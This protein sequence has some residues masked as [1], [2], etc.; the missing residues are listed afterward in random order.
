MTTDISV[1]VRWDPIN[2]Q[3][4]V[5]EDYEFDYDGGNSSSRLFERSRIKALAVEREHVQKK[6]F[7]KWVNSHLCRINCRVVDLYTDLRDGKLLIKLLEILSGERLPRPTRGKMRI[8]CLENVDKA[9]SFLYEQR[10]HLENMGAHDI[11]DGSPR[12][13][14]GLIWTIILRFQIQ[15]ITVEEPG[16]GAATRSAKDALLLWCQMK[17]AGYHNVN[18]R[19]FTTSWR[20]G[21]A[22]NAIIHKHRSD[23][24]QYERL[25]KSNAMYNLNNA[26][27]VADREFNLV[28]LLDA[29]DVNVE[30]PDEKSI[31]T[32]VVTYYHYFSKL[33]QETVQG[34]RIAKVVGIDMECD[35]MIEQYEGFT[36][37]LLKW[38]EN[39]IEAL[40]DRQFANSL[41]GVQEQ[42][43]QFN[44]YRNVEKPPKFMEKGN[45]EVLLFTLQSKMRANN[46]VPYFPKEGKTIS[47]INKAWER[48]EKA[49]HERELALREELIRQEKLEQL[50]ARFNR[51]AGMR[52]T[53][54]SENQRLVSQD[55]FGF[56]LAAVEAAAKKHEAIET[57]IFAYE[58]R[59]QA[60]IA[61]AHELETENYHDIECINARKDNVLRLWNYLLE[62]LKARRTR[63]EMSL[64]LQHNFQEMVYIL[65]SMEELK[66]RLLS[67]D[68]GKH[69]L[70]VEDLLQKHSLV[71]A[72]INVLGERVKQVVQHSQKFLADE[73]G[74]DD[75]KPCDPSII[76]ER[77]QT[78][79][80]AYAELVRLAVERRSRLEESRQMWQFYWDMAEE[81]NW[82]KEMEQI[83][84]QGDIGHDLT[85]IHLLLSKHKSL[86]TEIR[87]HEN[88]LQMSIKQGQDLIDQ[89]HFGADKVQTRIDDVMS[90]WSQ[91]VDLMDTRKRR[92]TEAVDFH[93]FL[94]DADD[95]DTYMLDVLRL[96]S[97]D[98][99]GKDE[100]NV[101]TLLKK[102]K[103]IHDD[104]MNFQSNVDAL[105]EQATTLGEN[106]K[107]AVEKRLASIDKRY[108]ELQEL[109][110]L[111]KQR[112]LD[113]LSLYKLFTEADGVEQWITEKEKMLDTMQ[114]GKDIEDC[115]IMKHRFDGF[116]R[117]MNANASR[118]AVVNQL[119][120]QLLHVDHPNSDDIVAR[121]NQLN[122]RWA[123]LR[124]QAEA[125]REQL[126]SAH[127]VQT[128][129]IECRETVT[130][131]EDKKR[132]LEQTDELKMDLTGIMTLQR[133]LSG[134]DRD[135]AAIEAKLKTLEDEANKIKDTHPDEA[136]V[137]FDR[138]EKLRGEWK[139]LNVMLHERE[140]K[141]EEAGDLHRFLKDLDHFQAWLTKTESSI[142]NEDTPSSLAEAEKLL[143]Q[144]QQ[145]REEIDS[146]T[147]DYTTMMDYGEKV[148]ADPSTF[149][150]PQY[151]FL[152]ERLKALRDGW[153]E[154]HQMWENRQQLLSQSLNL[155]MFNRDAKQ[156]EVLLSQQEHLLSK[157]ET[158]SNLEQAES[159]IK[160][161][162]ALLTTM[163]A[164]DD[165]VNGV[166]QFAQRLCSEQHFASDK[167][168][169]KAD[170][171]SERRNINHD[172][173]LQQLDKLRDQLLLHQF[174]QDC[175]E[176]HDWIQEKNVLVQEDTY[177]SAK[178][179]HSKWTRHQAF[180]SE[181]ASNKE[182]LDRV[183]ESGQELLKTKPEMADL[184]TPKLDELERDF[185]ALQKNTK[186]KGERIFDAK[187][188]DLYE[189]SCDDIDSF[190]MD[191]E[192][193]METE[194]IGNDL[195]SVNI[196]MQKQ[197]MIETQMQVKSMQV[198]ELETQAEKLV[199][200]EPDKR[201]VIEA[202]KEEVSKKFEAVMAPLEA[203]KKELLVKKEI[204]QFLRDLEDENIWIEEKMNLVTSD[205]FGSSLQ[206]VNL[207]IK[208]NKTLKGEIDN[209][210]PRILSVCEIGQKLI[211]SDH[212]DSEKFQKDIDEL[213]ENLNNLKEM[214]E[215]RRQ[216]LLVSEKAQQ[217]FF[218]ANEAEA[219]MSEQEL[220]MMVEDRGKDEFSAQN[221]MKKHTTLESA[222]ED[223]SENI[224]QLSESARQLIADEHPESE[225]IS[226][227]LAQVEKLYAGL[228]DLAAERKAKLD[229]A[230][231]LFMLNREVDDLEQWI[232][233]R[234][235]VA[236]SHELGQDYE[237]VT[238]LWERF[239]EFAKDTEI[240]GTERVAA[241]N[242]IADSLITSG[243]T[244]AATIAQW[245]DSLND[246]WADLGEL[247]E[248]RTQ[249]LEAS[250]E[251]H[252]Y[253]HDCKDVLGRILEKQ[254]SMPDDLGRD[255]G[256]VSSLTRKHQNFVQDLQGLEGQV[257][258]IQEESSK[259]QAAYAGEKA[260]EITN[261]E[262][263]V[264]R[265]W[266]E[267]NAMG[268]SR[269]NKL[270]DTSD[271]F[272]FF[273]MVRNLMLWMD[274]L[275]RQMSTSEK[276]R[277]V[278]GVELLMN[279]HQ[280]HKAEIDTRE[281]NFT[282]C[283]TLGKELLS[284]GHY[285]NNEIKEKL[286]ELTNQRNTMLLRWEE[287]WEH[288]QL[289]LEVYQ[290]ARD[291]AVAEAWLIA[292]DP[293]LKS[294]E[295]GQTIDEVENLIKKHEA[296]EKAAA[297]QEERFAALE[298]LTTF[299]LKE[300]KRR[301]E[302]DERRREEERAKHA[303][304]SY[305]RP[306]AGERSDV[307]SVK[308]GTPTG[309]TRQG[310][311]SKAAPTGATSPPG[312]ASG[313]TGRP[314]S[315]AGSVETGAIRRASAAKSPT[316]VT[317][318]SET[319][320]DISG[321]DDTSSNSSPLISSATLPPLPN[322][323]AK[324]NSSSSGTT[325][326]DSSLERPPKSTRPPTSPLKPPITFRSSSSRR[327]STA[328][329]KK[330]GKTRTRSKSPFRSFRWPKSKS[331]AESE[332]AAA[333]SYYSDDED[334]LRRPLS[335]RSDDEELESTLI[336]KHEWES[337]TKKTSNRS[338]DKLCVVLK[339]GSIGFY[340]D[341]K[342][343]KGAPS[344][345]YKGEP[346]VEISGATAEVASDYTKKKHVFRLKLNNG[347]MYLF[348]ARDDDEMSQW[349][350]AI[351][352][353]AGGEGPSGGARSQT[354]PTG[355]SGGDGKKEKKPFFTLKG[356]N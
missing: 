314:P 199:L 330:R 337:T 308:S 168:S 45:L 75:Y 194:P 92:L 4:E 151:M 67:D 206:A 165:K 240:I 346:P 103:E 233:E 129:H 52:E 24:I 97:S 12:L 78:L 51:K 280:G 192:R 183:Q 48:L 87:A 120:R 152:R 356:K 159:L 207:L 282:Q 300:I 109:S 53:W 26:F 211:A 212:P 179:I 18:I 90:M 150:D 245:K 200:M 63:L 169:K 30:M 180:E 98:D 166:L 290:F 332:A 145:I 117:E 187:R 2:Q 237:H 39:V 283:F 202:K 154:V 281:E 66:M 189:Q 38:I 14:L 244:D 323:S 226:I 279:N 5:I 270:H 94:T 16:P 140:A 156:A 177:R 174:L 163:E 1:G 44:S 289:I 267:L 133:K 126:G 276:P 47:D 347:G 127:G 29:E 229:D 3:N 328:S 101:Q 35:K 112:L 69:L 162:E 37:D 341:Q 259:L 184:I 84:S 114:P 135:M 190:V 42:L 28:K 329:E 32:Y 79:E 88:Q 149:E 261:R 83:L 354:L 58:E 99:I 209:H 251:L 68:Y 197:Q 316:P 132:V 8:H 160:K 167:I 287:R 268:D 170:D 142:A 46:K 23:L 246:S 312:G 22:F 307:G 345:T 91:L 76:V 96:V 342:A 232:A 50:A 40:G 284:R 256:A 13:T 294:G 128:F 34:K 325:G 182:R 201:N 144:H 89:G 297:A 324:R 9:L 313:P 327:G 121:Q 137:V 293:Y 249:M 242:Q 223:Y 124:E 43:T 131:I 25:S 252:K 340:K 65:D 255:A 331:K 292:Q 148:T 353:S 188:A 352:Q 343:Y 288:L 15:E 113:A 185:E 77:V 344:A 176:L 73:D 335:E 317:S 303:P 72:D 41:R 102:Q 181:I 139:Q 355:A 172:L 74:A 49:E 228:R 164:N 59:V 71:E 17:T 155:Q 111:R 115:E 238:L 204:F 321:K 241:A 305:D 141:L 100:S 203:R 326:L 105:H 247:I 178:T 230:L 122:Q 143:S 106:D 277:D 299:E 262:R 219:W 19:N 147:T 350:S 311:R 191:L 146:Y 236:G 10:V 104:L 254:H 195:T 248:T 62:L 107:P 272:K 193:Q 301:Q 21:L 11:V 56:D 339:N 269:K 265:A 136:Q 93:Q 60:V 110:K 80:D 239:R 271:L 171:I 309:V 210:E 86:E 227:R 266:L 36:S 54:L 250:R 85:T 82:I 196:L 302:E 157:D 275:T 7:T 258:A 158:P 320:G 291:A 263:E 55:N 175:E 33:K 348:Q 278:S 70:G 304:P 333:A 264:V 296:F 306:D 186:D 213:L 173:A 318:P 218:D 138:V 222:V 61:V 338:W 253:F 286:V 125:K 310:S 64:Q 295:L 351:N 123:D 216:K 298:R 217:F 205:E 257:K 119:A 319:G 260:M 134:M 221:L 118:V 214:L 116:D 130:W 224:R 161:H 20:D 95:V 315:G 336:R 243:H 31:I 198:S 334:N 349:V 6:T 208:K 225:Q 274:D 27:D 285:A 220:Y 215:I 231:K 57:D 108:N 322:K 234:E 81:E 235:V 153:A 273:N